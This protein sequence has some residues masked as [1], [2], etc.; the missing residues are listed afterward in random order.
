MKKYYNRL[1]DKQIKDT[2]SVM[3]AVLVQGPRVAVILP[4]FML[5]R[6]FFQ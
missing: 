1:V 3:G 2:L 4:V 6:H 5:K